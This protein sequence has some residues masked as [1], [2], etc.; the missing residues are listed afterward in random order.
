MT[1]AAAECE[2]LDISAVCELLKVKRTTLTRIRQQGFPR[3]ILVGR[4]KRW[5]PSE[6]RQWQEDCR[7]TR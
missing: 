6:V 4:S 2:L 3:P 7:R 1:N 5:I